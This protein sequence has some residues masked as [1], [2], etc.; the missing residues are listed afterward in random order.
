MRK[1]LWITTMFHVLKG[2]IF[3]VAPVALLFWHTKSFSQLPGS[4]TPIFYIASVCWILFVIVVI[5]VERRVYNSFIYRKIH[6]YE[7]NLKE[8]EK[9]K[10][11]YIRAIQN[12]DEMEA[13][14]TKI[15]PRIS[16]NPKNAIGSLKDMLSLERCVNQTITSIYY[17]YRNDPNNLPKQNYRVTFME[18]AND[19]ELEIEYFQS[20][21]GESPVSLKRKIRFKK[22]YQTCAGYAWLTMKYYKIQD[23]DQHCKARGHSS[24]CHFTHNH[25]EQYDIKSIFS[26]PIFDE[27][28]PEDNFYGVLNIDTNI[29]GRFIEMSDGKDPQ[30]E[31]IK[32][33]L[34]RIGYFYRISKLINKIS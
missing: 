14:I 11:R 21:G 32:P 16:E 26:I 27:P 3:I 7:E 9:D 6:S 18:P 10:Q 1:N 23:I 4:E 20:P 33:F 22:D 24:D 28:Q 17:F 5:L 13:S 2:V 8:I 29:P 12:L 15:L 30:L 19:S 31:I 25:D 34:K